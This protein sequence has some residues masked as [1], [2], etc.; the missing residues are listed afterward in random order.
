MCVGCV[1]SYSDLRLEVFMTRN[2]RHL[3]T[4]GES[5]RHKFWR[6]LLHFPHLLLWLPEAPSIC[7]HSCKRINHYSPCPAPNP[8]SMQVRQAFEAGTNSSPGLGPG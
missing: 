1:I 8:S 2:D 3:Q 5:D 6:M 4:L 7:Y